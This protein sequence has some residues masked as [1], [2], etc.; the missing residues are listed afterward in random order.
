MRATGSC[1]LLLNRVKPPI[2][3]QRC[4]KRIDLYYKQI[5]SDVDLLRKSLVAETC[6][7]SPTGSQRNKSHASNRSPVPI[8]GFGSYL[9]A[10]ALSIA[11][12]TFAEANSA[13]TRIPFITA[14]SFDDPCPTMQTPRTP[15]NCAP[16]YS[17]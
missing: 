17:E 13:A 15:S 5:E 11:P 14:L 1:D 16:P 9:A 6:D 12:F 7:D 8:S 10:S 4:L 3:V 2:E